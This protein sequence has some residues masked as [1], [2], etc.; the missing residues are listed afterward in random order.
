[1][2]LCS[3]ELHVIMYRSQSLTL[4]MAPLLLPVPEVQA[5]TA[6]PWLRCEALSLSLSVI[7]SLAQRVLIA[8]DNLT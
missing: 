1:M 5:S 2:P 3:H 4:N 8:T 7:L 6:R